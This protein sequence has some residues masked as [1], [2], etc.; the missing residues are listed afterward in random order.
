MSCMTLVL[1]T[2]ALLT[3]FTAH[4]SISASLQSE[5]GYTVNVEQKCL[6]TLL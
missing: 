6:G 3:G 2:A 1:E 5:T 4:S